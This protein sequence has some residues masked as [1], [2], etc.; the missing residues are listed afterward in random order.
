M[1]SDRLTIGQIAR[2]S[3]LTR[4]SLRHYD[5]LGVLRPAGVDGDNGYR[6]YSREQ[7]EVARR[8]RALRAL[9]VPLDEIR[10][11]LAGD[12]AD[13]RLAAHRRRVAA[14]LDR[15]R[16]IHY[17][18]GKD[19]TMPKR[20]TEIAVDPAERRRLAGELF[21]YT[22][23]YLEKDDRTEEETERMI[24]AAHASRVFWLDIGTP[25]NRGR[26][27]WQL[28]RVYATAGRAEQ[29]LHHAKRCLAICEEHGTGDFDLACA[30]E[31]LARAYA[32]A[33]DAD[34]AARHEALGREAAVRV[35]DDEDRELVLGDLATLPRP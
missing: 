9:D 8:I 35:E 25:V 23:T 7:V 1:S 16:T 28:A 31:A 5:E 33:G 22:W 12:D 21:N 10:R 17:F 6:S 11:I 19:A 13:A 2:L 3:G 15:L 34:A 32:V 20:P 4:R 18:L 27:E 14:Q 29:A 26:G 30:H 24:S